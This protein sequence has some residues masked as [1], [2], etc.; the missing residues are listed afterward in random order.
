MTTYKKEIQKLFKNQKQRM[1]RLKKRG[2][3]LDDYKL[4]KM[5][6]S[7]GKK[8]LER[9][10]KSLTLENLYKKATK[11]IDGKV[12]SGKK[13]RELER[14]AAG[15]KA[16]ETRKQGKTAGVELVAKLIIANYRE[17]VDDS[18]ASDYAKRAFNAMLNEQISRLTEII[19][20]KNIQ[21]NES[22]SNKWLADLVRPSA[23]EEEVELDVFM[24]ASIMFSGGLPAEERDRLIE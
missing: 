5:P 4:P 22:K 21:A 12:I 14:S 1:N 13:A 8:T 10:Q 19:V 24:I 6:T 9:L 3:N 11:E 2:Y 7:F 17:I 23:N 16:S 15:K 18:D 20:A